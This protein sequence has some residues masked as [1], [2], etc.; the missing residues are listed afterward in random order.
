MFAQIQSFSCYLWPM[1]N[2]VTV[3]E[4]ESLPQCLEAAGESWRSS[5]RSRE[6]R[7]PDVHSEHEGKGP[8]CTCPSLGSH[9]IFLHPTASYLKISTLSRTPSL[10]LRGLK[11]MRTLSI[12][13]SPSSMLISLIGYTKSNI[14]CSASMEK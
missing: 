6:P 5:A 8:R 14:R 4:L 10:L 7:I 11:R 12:Q 2:I 3:T 9:T 13:N 1:N